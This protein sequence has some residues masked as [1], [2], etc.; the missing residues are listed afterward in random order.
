MSDLGFG[1]A[2]SLKT[3]SKLQRPS[4]AKPT[5]LTHSLTAP[6]A[7]QPTQTVAKPASDKGEFVIFKRFNFKMTV[8]GTFFFLNQNY[9]TRSIYVLNNPLTFIAVVRRLRQS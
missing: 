2:S 6:A 1:K 3:P 5:V 7:S 9:E 4:I 8:Q